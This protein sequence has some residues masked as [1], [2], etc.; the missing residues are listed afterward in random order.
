MLTMMTWR[1]C[2]TAS[3]R[4]AVGG[5][6]NS[7]AAIFLSIHDSWNVLMFDLSE[8]EKQNVCVIFNYLFHV[9]V[10]KLYKIGEGSFFFVFLPAQISSHPSSFYKHTHKHKH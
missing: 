3:G 4:E 8:C 1:K 10:Q 2:W 6:A 9:S 7:V 5:A